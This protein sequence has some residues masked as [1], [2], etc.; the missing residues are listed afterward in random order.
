MVMLLA[1]LRPY[2][3]F[4]L[5]RFLAARHMS[6]YGDTC[7]LV[8]SP[9]QLRDIQVSNPSSLSILDA[10]WHMPNAPRKANKEFLE[11]H[12]PGARYL[13]LD[14][15][16]S[17]HELGLMHMMPTGKVFTDACGALISSFSIHMAPLKRK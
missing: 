8:V 12:I 4:H 14:Q 2:R 16:A 11:K 5:P 13:D 10:S 7:P 6:I 17:P 15:V 3:A 9:R 1:R